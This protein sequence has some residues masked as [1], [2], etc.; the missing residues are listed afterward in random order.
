MLPHQR[1]SLI[2]LACIAIWVL[3]ASAV[4]YVSWAPSILNHQSPTYDL[5]F[6]FEPCAVKQGKTSLDPLTAATPAKKPGTLVFSATGITYKQPA[7]RNAAGHSP[8]TVEFKKLKVVDLSGP[9]DSIAALKK[10]LGNPNLG[11]ALLEVR[12]DAAAPGP[13]DVMVICTDKIE[14]KKLLRQAGEALAIATRTNGILLADALDKLGDPKSQLKGETFLRQKCLTFQDRDPK[15]NLNWTKPTGKSYEVAT[16]KGP[17]VGKYGGIRIY[18]QKQGFRVG[19]GL[20]QEYNYDRKTDKSFHETKGIILHFRGTKSI[21]EWKTNLDLLTD[22]FKERVRTYH[23]GKFAL[24]P[25]M[26]GL[27]GL[28]KLAGSSTKYAGL[29]R[30][31]LDDYVL[32]ELQKWPNAEVFLCGHSLGGF[33]AQLAG[34]EILDTGH[35]KVSVAVTAAPGGLEVFKEKA[36]QLFGSAPQ[37]GA[38]DPTKFV[39]IV[40]YMDWVRRLGRQPG[41]QCTIVMLGKDLAK[42]GQ[43]SAF[44]CGKPAA[45]QLKGIDDLVGECFTEV[46]M[47]TVPDSVGNPPRCCLPEQDDCGTFIPWG[48]AKGFWGNTDFSLFEAKPDTETTGYSGGKKKTTG[49]GTTMSG[50]GKSGGNGGD[51]G[52]LDGG[53]SESGSGKGGKGG[54]DE[55]ASSTKSKD[56]DAGSDKSSDDGSDEGNSGQKGNEKDKGKQKDG[57][58]NDE[59]N[60]G[61]KD[62]DDDGFDGTGSDER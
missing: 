25:W 48:A 23:D 24:A 2:I 10:K 46:H 14:V 39:N 3:P 35:T 44:A 53:G 61:P 42:S 7:S 13:T 32:P 9:L 5:A 62:D 45:L 56:D 8:L 57:D 11:C 49:G 12:A 4:T 34:L 37:A 22:A 6:P 50:G 1:K 60:S 52:D 58:G 18:I 47:D 38:P 15:R 40:Q 28:G 21:A 36:Q 20:I 33:V 29:V 17:I 41:Y 16:K 59:G 26:K 19:I 54:D 51:G 27:F 31:A 55:D 43:N 30:S